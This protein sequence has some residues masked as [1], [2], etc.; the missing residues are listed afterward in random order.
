MSSAW[1]NYYGDPVAAISCQACDCNGNIIL[2]VA[3]NCDNTSGICLK[4]VNNT[5]GDY[6]EVCGAGYYGDAI[7]SKDCM[8]C[9]CDQQGNQL[10]N[11]LSYF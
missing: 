6:C 7:L 11:Q 8:E 3:G 2:N 10:C 9:D 1:D 4:C 5:S